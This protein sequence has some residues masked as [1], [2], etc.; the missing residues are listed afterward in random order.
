MLE[1]TIQQQIGFAPMPAVAKILSRYDRSQLEDFISVAIGLLDVADGDPDLET[2]DSDYE[3]DD[4]AKGDPSWTEWHTR[5]RRKAD[6]GIH[7]RHGRS[8]HEDAEDDDPAGEYD[9]DA[10]TGTRPRGHGPGCII[11][12]SDIEHDGREEVYD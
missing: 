10:Y 4:D 11:S 7:D 6:P 3:P 2:D 1:G 12:D 8:M 5:G 9:E